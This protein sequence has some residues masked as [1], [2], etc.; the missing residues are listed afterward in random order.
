MPDKVAL[1]IFLAGVIALVVYGCILTRK[2][3]K[4]REISRSKESTPSPAA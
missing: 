3:T 4:S 1:G 2:P